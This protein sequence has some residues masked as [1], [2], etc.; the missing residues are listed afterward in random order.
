MTF[1][2]SGIIRM[3]PNVNAV[4]Q[5]LAK[6]RFIYIYETYKNDIYI[7]GKNIVMLNINP[8]ILFLNYIAI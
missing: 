8:N 7:V 3:Y 4:S 2:K 6:L 1:I 5:C